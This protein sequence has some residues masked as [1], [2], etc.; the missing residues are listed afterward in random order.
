MSVARVHCDCVVW[1]WSRS[2]VS[3]RV[4]ILP[5]VRTGIVVS[6]QPGPW[7]VKEGLNEAG[8][9]QAARSLG[10]EMVK[11]NRAQTLT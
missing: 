10:A 2:R 8:P 4:V 9:R 1:V 3:P 6:V 5:C 7:M 11:S